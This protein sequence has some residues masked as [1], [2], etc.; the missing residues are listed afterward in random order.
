M[1]RQ[2][3]AQ[4]VFYAGVILCL[5]LTIVNTVN[6]DWQKTSQV[7]TTLSIIVTALSVLAA[8]IAYRG[9]IS[10][11]HYFAIDDLYFRLLN[12]SM[13]HP[14]LRDPA[15]IEKWA[16]GE[17]N[18]VEKVNQYETYAFMVWNF[19]ETICD[20]G[21]SYQEVRDTWEPILIRE[22]SLH[23]AWFERTEN[24]QN[25]K[26]PFVKEIEKH[27]RPE[28]MGV[29]DYQDGN[30]KLLP[31]FMEQISASMFDWMQKQKGKDW[32]EAMTRRKISN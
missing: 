21:R 12:L 4:R 10:E 13:Q 28:M 5:V 23:W 11:K 25:F 18:D 8:V 17:I 16:H 19:V 26:E 15:F 7:T 2:I 3:L 30:Y 29:S 14:H 24:R 32:Q 22:S 27:L 6:I 1:K 9:Q 31:A 20:R